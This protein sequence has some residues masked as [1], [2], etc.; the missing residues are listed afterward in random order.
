MSSTCS[1]SPAPSTALQAS[2]VDCEHG[3]SFHAT[4]H[5]GDDHAAP[6]LASCSFSAVDA[7]AL[8]ARMPLAALASYH[9]PSLSLTVV[10]TRDDR[11]ADGKV[12]AP[13]AL[14]HSPVHSIDA[15]GR[16][17]FL[18]MGDDNDDIVMMATLGEDGSLCLWFMRVPEGQNGTGNEDEADDDGDEVTEAFGLSSLPRRWTLVPDVTRYLE[19]LDWVGSEGDHGLTCG[20]AINAGVVPSSPPSSPPPPPSHA[21][22]PRPPGPS[23]DSWPLVEPLIDGHGAM[24]AA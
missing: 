21:R 18:P 20:D 2:A 14:Y 5:G 17:Q 8:E 7:S 12:Y 22:M 6:V 15:Y 4:L 1:P 13:Y 3:F 24:S 19:G 16:L 23:F 10:V 11:G 9:G